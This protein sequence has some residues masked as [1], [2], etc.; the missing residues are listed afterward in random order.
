MLEIAPSGHTRNAMR[1]MELIREIDPKLSDSKY[2]E[3]LFGEHPVPKK[4][5]LEWYYN[6]LDFGLLNVPSGHFICMMRDPN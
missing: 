1:Q 3:T 5:R 4:L 2:V 6:H